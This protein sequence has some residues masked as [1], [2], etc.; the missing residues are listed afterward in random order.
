M[1]KLWEMNL[2][3][4]NFGMA[5]IFFWKALEILCLFGVHLVLVISEDKF[6]LK[7]YI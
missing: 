5:G 3:K 7:F 4:G 1:M 6:F 2:G